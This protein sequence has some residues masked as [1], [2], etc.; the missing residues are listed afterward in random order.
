[1]AL[2]LTSLDEQQGLGLEQGN[3]FGPKATIHDV[4][5]AKGTKRGC[6]G[7]TGYCFNAKSAA[8]VPGASRAYGP[9]N[10]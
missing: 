4:V 1:M 6:N 10:R 3:L 9:A 7:C 5:R 8:S 2:T